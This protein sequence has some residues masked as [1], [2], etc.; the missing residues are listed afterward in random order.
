MFSDSQKRELLVNCNI[1]QKIECEAPND[2]ID[3]VFLKTI[4]LHCKNQ[5]IYQRKQ[6]AKKILT[7]VE[8]DYLAIAWES[9]E[10]VK[11]LTRSV[12]E[13]IT[14]SCIPSKSTASEFLFV[15]KF[16]SKHLIS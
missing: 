13:I 6:L 4:I 12:G 16:F 15:A 2:D 3:K 5:K 10:E 14:S 9:L 8:T 1:N 11:E 7:P